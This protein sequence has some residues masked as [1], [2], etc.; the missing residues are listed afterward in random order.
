MN[1]TCTG[2]PIR[3]LFI[4]IY[5]HLPAKYT[6]VPIHV[7]VLKITLSMLLTL[8][9]LSCFSWTRHLSSYSSFWW[10]SLRLS[11]SFSCSDITISFC[12]WKSFNI[13]AFSCS[14]AI[15]SS[16]VYKTQK[17]NAL[18]T[19]HSL[20]LVQYHYW[21]I[22]RINSIGKESKEKY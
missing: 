17:E 19:T 10:V 14:K 7:I 4:H 13:W 22:G 20:F 12:V 2:S 9:S 11:I 18:H 6:K 8:V 3:M 16:T 15:F 5:V 1:C 21:N